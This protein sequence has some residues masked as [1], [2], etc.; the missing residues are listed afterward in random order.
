MSRTLASLPPSLLEI[1]E[2]SNQQTLILVAQLWERFK[3]ATFNRIGVL[4]QAVTV[5]LEGTLS[6]ELR[7][8]AACDAHKLAGSVGMFGFA[9]GSRLASMIEQML[10]AGAP[11]GQAEILR[12]SELIVLLRRTLEQPSTVES[13]YESLPE[14]EHLPAVGE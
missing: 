1:A 5:L 8:Q 7:R 10:E 13:E 9:A 11:L 14:T 3:E 6:D 4:E 2:E 12:L